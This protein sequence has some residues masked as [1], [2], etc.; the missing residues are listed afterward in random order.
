MELKRDAYNQLS[1]L[2]SWYSWLQQAIGILED[3]RPGKW[4]KHHGK[5][6]TPPRIPFLRSY[7][8]PLF[9]FTI[10]AR[11]YTPVGDKVFKKH[12]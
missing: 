1:T 9:F 4:M 8:P 10:R 6:E 2:T 5:D 11:S 7:S 12:K 3:L